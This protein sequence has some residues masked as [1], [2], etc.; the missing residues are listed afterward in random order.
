MRGY[1]QI[2]VATHRN[3]FGNAKSVYDSM[4]SR[5]AG[6]AARSRVARDDKQ[7]RSTFADEERSWCVP[8]RDTRVP[9]RDRQTFAMFGASEKL[10]LEMA[11]Q[12]PVEQAGGW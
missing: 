11:N 3:R 6:R 10:Y 1:E 4:L 7:L 9:T 12:D 8:T 5:R 2:L